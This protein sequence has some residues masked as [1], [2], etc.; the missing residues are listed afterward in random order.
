MGWERSGRRSSALTAPSPSLGPLLAHTIFI[1]VWESDAATSG[2]PSQIASEPP[3]ILIAA[4]VL[5]S[6]DF[7]PLSAQAHTN[8]SPPWPC[9]EAYVGWG[10][11][12]GG[13]RCIATPPQ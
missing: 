7:S 1:Q 11:V 12:E 2:S 3:C 4:V 13:R 8:G 9:W 6:G 5:C 10:G